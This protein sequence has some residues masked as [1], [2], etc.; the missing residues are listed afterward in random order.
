MLNEISN[1]TLFVAFFCLIFI[2]DYSYE[3]SYLLP[4]VAVPVALLYLFRFKALPTDKVYWSLMAFFI[5]LFMIKA[6]H[7]YDYSYS[8]FVFGV[9]A[10]AICT[11]YYIN[12]VAKTKGAYFLAWVSLLL[13]SLAAFTSDIESSR[14][15]LIFGP[16]ILYRVIGF[17]WG[18]ILLYHFSHPFSVRRLWFTLLASGFSVYLLLKTGS[19]G[20]VLVLAV[21]LMAIAYISHLKKIVLGA[22]LFLILAFYFYYVMELAGSRSF[23]FTGESTDVRLSKFE[24]FKMF[25]E[26]PDI[27][28]GSA[29]PTMYTG[30]YPHNIL[31]EFFIYYGVIGGGI[32]LVCILAHF[33]SLFYR[34]VLVLFLPL[35]PIAIGVQF[36]GSNMDNYAFVAVAALGTAFFIKNIFL[37]VRARDASPVSNSELRLP[38]QVR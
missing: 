34:N 25:I 32:F 12:V 2:G 3:G 10:T 5:F 21:M 11:P 4:F 31:L 1:A 37:R 17:L 6:G 13:C 19:R 26:S 22:P 16:T 28:W 14:F 9:V 27:W 30:V 24:A 29:N 7:F 36:S 18:G 20:A 15:S 8:F 23:R 33:A 35:L 38:G